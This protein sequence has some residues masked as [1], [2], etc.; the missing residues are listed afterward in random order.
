MGLLRFLFV[1]LCALTGNVTIAQSTSNDYERS[2]LCIML[3][4]HHDQIHE[5]IIA[6]IFEDVPFPERFYNH[7]LGVKAIAFQGTQGEKAH[8]IGSFCQQENVGQKMVAKWFNR[9]KSTGSFNMEL[10]KERGL[11]NSTQ[12]QQNVA[13]ASMR[14]LS[15][16][17]DAGENLIKNTYLVVNDVEYYALH[18]KLTAIA[19]SRITKSKGLNTYK[20]YSKVRNYGNTRGFI[21][22]ITTYLFRLKWSED[23]AETFYNNY[24]TEDGTKDNYKVL[25]F[26]QDAARWGMEY[27]GKNFCFEEGLDKKGRMTLRTLLT[28]LS[29]RA[30]DKN[31]AQ[32]QHNYPDFRIKAPLTSVEPL[33]AYV[34]L[35]EDITPQ[36]RFE[37]LERVIDKKG[38]LSYRRVGVIKPKANHIWDNRYMADDED[39]DAR[40]GYTEFEKVSGGEML[41]GMLI[42]EIESD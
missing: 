25:A 14:G 21:V 1:S 7:G 15:L 38:R 40:L 36:S 30:L 31:L 6:D 3:I 9:D 26:K 39:A 34:G 18:N 17:A 2:S 10:V 22:Q 32:L 27:V 28:K 16:M 20:Y 33:K 24:Y 35:K 29:T 11:F 19:K 13:R 12:A 4:K 42:R 23:D 41:P 5:D 8:K 37:V